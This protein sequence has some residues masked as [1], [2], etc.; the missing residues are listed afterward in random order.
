MAFKKLIKSGAHCELWIIGD[1]PTRPGIEKLAA[2]LGIQSSVRFLGTVLD[3]SEFYKKFDVFVL[4]THFEGHS[5]VALEAMSFG[6]PIVATRVSSIPEVITDNV[7]GLLFNPGDSVQL[8]RSIKMLL[9]DD[10]L[11]NRISESSLN[12]IK[13]LPTTED[14]ATNV[15]SSYE[16][17]L[18]LKDK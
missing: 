15:L 3:T 4:S 6:L 18:K 13:T 16:Y 9:D 8:A 5:L 7:N 17:V 10:D 11:Y 1:G 2:D 12:G 14:W